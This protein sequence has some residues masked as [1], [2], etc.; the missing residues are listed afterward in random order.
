MILEMDAGNTLVKWRVRQGAE[1]SQRGSYQRSGDFSIEL[2]GQQ[3]LEAIYISSV[4]GVEYEH[5]LTRSL[6]ASFSV[7]PWFAR[8]G[9][10]CAGVSNSYQNP[11]LMGVDRWL[12]MLAAYGDCRSA[13]CVVDAGSALTIDFVMADGA[14]RGGYILPGSELMKST[15]LKNTDR[16]RFEAGDVEKLEP[17]TSTVAAVNNGVLLSQT[18]AVKLALQQAC[19]NG[20]Q[21]YRLYICGGDGRT[22]EQALAVEACYHPE[23]VL[24]GLAL[25]VA[26]A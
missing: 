22:L 23:L 17:G 7:R 16:V 5:E 15:L 9:A 21:D 20:A 6:L 19:Q 8:S 3:Q 18:G 1:I 12:A 25:A 11:E 26:E 10:R 13:V 4:A 24:D 2:E 14:H